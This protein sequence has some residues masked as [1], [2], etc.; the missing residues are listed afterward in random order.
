MTDQEINEAVAR[1]LGWTY[2]NK[3]EP[4]CWK[5]P[6]DKACYLSDVFDYCHSISSAWEVMDTLTRECGSVDLCWMAGSKKWNCNFMKDFTKEFMHVQEDSAP[7]A[8]CQAFLK[9]RQTNATWPNS[10]EDPKS[11]AL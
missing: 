10:S 6:G 2:N 7:K 9:S 8:I 3:S 11:A 4:L 5:S 1:G